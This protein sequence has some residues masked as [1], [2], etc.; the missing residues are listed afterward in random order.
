MAPIDWAT[1]DESVRRTRRLVVAHEAVVTGGLGAELVA[2]VHATAFEAL[3]SPALRVGAPSAPVP[4]SP[5]L[6]RLYVPD[7][8]DVV[9]AVLK[10]M[11]ER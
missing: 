9:S 10:T 7:I 6:E 8:D 3:V 4:A 11:Q 2:G 1:I 5:F